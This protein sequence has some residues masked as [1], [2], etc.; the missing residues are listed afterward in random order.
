MPV[1]AGE[2]SEPFAVNAPEL[3]ITEL[4]PGPDALSKAV[5]TKELN[6]IRSDVNQSA[7]CEG[8]LEM[9]HAPLIRLVSLLGADGRLRREI[10]FSLSATRLTELP[11]GR[12][13]L[14]FAVVFL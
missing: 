4:V 9:F 12:G 1:I 13:Y 8:R 3:M 2:E 11:P 14:V 5:A 7:C 10:Y 6:R